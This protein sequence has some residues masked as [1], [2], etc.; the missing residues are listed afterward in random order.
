M[1]I[2]N[3][4]CVLSVA[5]SLC[6]LL[7]L[8]CSPWAW[9]WFA[10]RKNRRLISNLYVSFW[11]APHLQGWY[12]LLCNT[13]VRGYIKWCFMWSLLGST[14]HYY[15]EG[16]ISQQVK[17]FRRQ[18]L[19]LSQSLLSGLFCMFKAGKKKI[20]QYF[21]HQS[22]VRT[23]YTTFLYR[24]IM[25]TCASTAWNGKLNGTLSMKQ[26]FGLTCTHITSHI[27]RCLFSN[28]CT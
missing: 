12:K 24:W 4:V 26:L 5:L 18:S 1:C 15:V 17:C 25:L 8:C 14:I 20:L 2:C 27:L 13:N 10:N 11:D 23:W 16:I 9:L 6:L 19:S 28:I 7:P 22:L 3:C 21:V